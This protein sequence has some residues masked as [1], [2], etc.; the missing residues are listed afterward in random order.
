[1]K[2]IV[3]ASV[4]TALEQNQ[5]QLNSQLLNKLLNNNYGFTVS[6]V[7]TIASIANK[8]PLSDGNAV[9]QARTLLQIIKNQYMEFTDSCDADK[10]SV[11]RLG[12]GTDNESDYVEVLPNN[13]LLFPNPNN[14]EFN[15]LY[16]L[17]D[18]Q[19]AIKVSLFDVAGKLVYQKELDT[20]T[21]FTSLNTIDLM[22]GIYHCIIT[23]AK[24]IQLY[25][26]KLVIIK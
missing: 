23:D 1:M 9:Y 13:F 8:C 18:K 5:Q 10:P 17:N 7:N 20:T 19:S 14:G 15:V 21:N 12:K 3:S 16:N 22:N 2:N 24:D 6:D 11:A 25:T 4:G 26:N